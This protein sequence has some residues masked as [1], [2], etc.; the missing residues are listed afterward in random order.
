MPVGPHSLQSQHI[1]HV[2]KAGLLQDDP[3]RRAQRAAGKGLAA[4]RFVRQLQ[5]LA[6]RG[7]DH[8][9]VADDVSSTDRMN[10]NFFR[11]ALAHDAFT[12]ASAAK[13]TVARPK[14]MTTAR[15]PPS[16][17]A[18]GA[19]AGVMAIMAAF[20]AYGRFTLAPLT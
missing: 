13:P 12:T 20:I 2:V 3:L 14:P 15:A 1:L 7:E 9:M 11:S 5:T 4:G 8:R 17:A 16:L 10:S 18:S 19:M 6:G